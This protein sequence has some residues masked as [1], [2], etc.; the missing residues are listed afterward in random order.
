MPI[1]CVVILEIVTYNSLYIAN[2]YDNLIQNKQPNK[3][4]FITDILSS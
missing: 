2:K 1:C 4:I 3:F